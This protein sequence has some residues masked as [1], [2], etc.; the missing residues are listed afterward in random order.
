MTLIS[1]EK[2]AILKIDFWKA[3]IYFFVISASRS[4][5]FCIFRP[6]YFPILKKFISRQFRTKKFSILK[7]DFWWAKIY[8]FV[9][10][11]SR[12]VIFCIFKVI[13]FSNVKETFFTS[14]FEEKISILKIDFLIGQNIIF[15]DQRITL[16][17][18]PHC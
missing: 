12:S 15:R 10:S 1:D 6:F 8:F 9:I 16:S 18:I 3:K 11:P 4:V 2:I 7:I 14:I 17:H 5:I 13:V